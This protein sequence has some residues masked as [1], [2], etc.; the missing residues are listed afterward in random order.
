MKTKRKLL[1]PLQITHGEPQVQKYI[2]ISLNGCISQT[3]PRSGC[4]FVTL[5]VLRV[6]ECLSSLGAS[7]WAGHAKCH[8][9]P[10]S[11]PIFF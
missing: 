3:L 9:S 1:L 10:P 4:Q 2:Q 6:S 11:L 5:R 8:F 7:A